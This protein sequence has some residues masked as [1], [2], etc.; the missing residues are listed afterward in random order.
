MAAPFFVAEG[1]PIKFFIQQDI[2]EHI[3]THLVQ[4]VKDNGGVV[5]QKVPLR[6]YLLLDFDSPESQRLRAVWAKSHR[7]ERYF[8]DYTFVDA[9]ISRRGLLPMVFQQNGV[10][11]DI[12]LHACIE[13]GNERVAL[14][15]QISQ[16]G[17]NP[18]AEEDQASVIIAEETSP[19]WTALQKTYSNNADKHVEPTEWVKWCITNTFMEHWEVVK[20]D[21]GGRKAGASRNEYTAA[22][23]K[24]LANYIAHL[25]PT[26]DSS[27]RT[28]NKI[29]KDLE[30]LV[31]KN[32]DYMWASRHSWQSWRNRYKQNQQ[33]FNRMIE[34]I[35][36]QLGIKPG[37]DGQYGSIRQPP[38]NNKRPAKIAPATL[39]EEDISEQIQPKATRRHERP[40]PSPDGI[41]IESNS[42]QNVV[43][44]DVST[45]WAT[46]EGNAPAPQWVKDIARKR[47]LPRSDEST[48]HPS[49]KRNLGGNQVLE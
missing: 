7:P 3:K 17:G 19:Q 21:L 31:Q 13:E 29:Y 41:Q 14:R 47:P 9:C 42:N 18:D 2:P 15:A 33:R 27:G 49:K 26:S 8:V 37:G 1:K 35:V 46:R 44:E 34:A 24:H 32:P 22:E 16:C 11:H 25:I 30:T 10:P 48:G 23:D 4:K 28:G 5:E 45:E 12:H 36:E 6:G 20:R 39:N 40:L 38:G 43:E